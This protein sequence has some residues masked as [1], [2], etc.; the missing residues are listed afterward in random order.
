MKLK[1][2]ENNNPCL[3][4]LP[5]SPGKAAT[6]WVLMHI[7]A[8]QSTS[9]PLLPQTETRLNILTHATLKETSKAEQVVKML[10]YL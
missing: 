7:A 2:L 9:I 3:P 8:S 1:I 6:I 10:T 4:Y 5:I